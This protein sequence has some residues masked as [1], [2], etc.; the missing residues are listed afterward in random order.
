MSISRQR[1]IAVAAAVLVI[2][3]FGLSASAS[4]AVYWTAGSLIGRAANDG[5]NQ[6]Q[7]FIGV[8]GSEL[9]AGACGIA[10]DAS[11]IY[12]AERGTNQIARADLNGANV[13]K[14]FITGADE[15]CSV[16]VNAEFIYW[17]NQGGQSIG[18]ARLDGSAVDQ[19]FIGVIDFPC[20]IAVTD[21]SIYWATPNEDV[22]GRASITGANIEKH[23]IKEANGSC[24][25]AADS[26]HIYWGTFDSSIGRANLDGSEPTADFIAGLVRPCGLAI[27][28]SRIYWSEEGFSGGSV[29]EANLDGTQVNPGFIASP[30][31]G[32]GVAVDDLAVPG[33]APPQGKPISPSEVSFGWVKYRRGASKTMTLL[34]VEVGG[35][36][37]YRV[38]VPRGVGWKVLSQE[39]VGRFL[40]GGRKW[41]SFW[42]KKGA[43]GRKLTQTLQ[44]K[45]RVQI[46][47]TF[48]FTEAGHPEVA[49][50]KKL[51]LLK[52]LRR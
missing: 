35:P 11:H 42:V 27:H 46:G 49:K 4:G 13:V 6:N 26:G 37:L 34:A 23:F 10:V 29:G 14:G 31:S 24:G 48:S 51:F 20:G 40:K 18:R 28:D 15:P 1:S 39:P 3:L 32:C 52:S 16:A 17:A 19:S 33:P 12:W 47:V 43:V 7:A 21:S 25:V 38:K 45:G 41:L 2:V 22:V 36:G 30:V 50:K 5:G 8:P 9:L 44:K